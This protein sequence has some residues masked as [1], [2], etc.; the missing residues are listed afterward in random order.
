MQGIPTPSFQL[1]GIARGKSVSI[2]RVSLGVAAWATDPVGT[3]TVTFSG[4][5]SGSEIRIYLPD[6]TE[7][8]GIETCASN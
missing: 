5:N 4:V 8:A 6:S 1:M 7:A 2:G 3:A